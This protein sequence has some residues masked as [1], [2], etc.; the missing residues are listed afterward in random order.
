MRAWVP[1][2]CAGRLVL[3]PGATPVAGPALRLTSHL[4]PRRDA[5]QEADTLAVYI[6][7]TALPHATATEE[8]NGVRATL[9]ASATL[10]NPSKSQDRVGLWSLKS[11]TVVERA[12]L[13][14]ELLLYE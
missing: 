10:N 11:R 5:Q 4:G 1:I 13:P 2:S 14:V 3:L 7:V 12:G 6:S 9:T 8:E